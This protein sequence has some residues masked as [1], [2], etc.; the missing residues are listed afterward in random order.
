MDSIDSS[1]RFISDHDGAVLLDIERDQFF[2][3]NPMGS[4]IW[5]RL[6]EGAPLDRIKAAIAEETGM[7]LSVVES[8][9]DEFIA[10]L[11]A[12]KLLQVSVLS[13]S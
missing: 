5:R 1:I 10:E 3:L 13:R 2:S 7:D 9:V 11:K 6:E 8:D 4:L 12:K